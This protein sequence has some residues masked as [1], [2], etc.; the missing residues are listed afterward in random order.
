MWEM[1]DKKDDIYNNKL[2]FYLENGTSNGAGCRIGLALNAHSHKGVSE[3]NIL[4]AHLLWITPNHTCW[5]Y[6]N[7]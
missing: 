1:C 3:Y 6:I 4:P 7:I 2:R 5:V